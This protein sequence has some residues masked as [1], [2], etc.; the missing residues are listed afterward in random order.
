MLCCNSSS[1]I[2]YI[3]LIVTEALDM[4]TS[5]QADLQNGTDKCP[6]K[7]LPHDRYG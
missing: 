6:F 3:F 4:L 5:Y 2:R 7:E 1:L